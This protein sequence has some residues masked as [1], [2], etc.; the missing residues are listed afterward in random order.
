MRIKAT[1]SIVLFAGIVSVAILFVDDRTLSPDE[2]ENVRTVCEECHGEVPE[3][4][5]AIKVHNK[6]AAFEC[7]F[8]HRDIGLLRTADSIHKTIEWIGLGTFSIALMG[9]LMNSFVRKR[10]N[11]AG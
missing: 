3:Y 7:S 10:N 1:I 9:V 11:R 6:H 8:C 5:L 2:L 4:E